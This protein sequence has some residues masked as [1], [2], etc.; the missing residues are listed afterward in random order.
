[1]MLRALTRPFPIIFRSSGFADPSKVNL[2]K[3]PTISWEKKGLHDSPKPGSLWAFAR[4]RDWVNEVGSSLGGC[5]F[6]GILAGNS[7]KSS[8]GGCR[9]FLFLFGDGMYRESK[10]LMV[11]IDAKIWVSIVYVGSR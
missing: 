7:S 10:R 4:S 9:F 11:G 3:S 5:A 1:M 8:Q 2:S 6:L